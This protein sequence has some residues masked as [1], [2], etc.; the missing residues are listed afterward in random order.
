MATPWEFAQARCHQLPQGECIRDLGARVTLVH[1]YVLHLESDMSAWSNHCAAWLCC[2]NL[3]VAVFCNLQKLIDVHHS[4]AVL[5]PFY[6]KN[7][8][9][10]HGSCKKMIQCERCSKIQS[11]VISNWTNIP[12]LCVF[13]HIRHTSES[14]PSNL[15]I[16][17]LTNLETSNRWNTLAHVV[18]VSRERPGCGNA[19]SF[20]KIC[21]KAMQ[22]V[23]DHD[24]LSFYSSEKLLRV[25]VESNSR[26]ILHSMYQQ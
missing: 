5:F 16:D 24:L 11:D 10:G 20:S 22:H 2:Y 4:F 7:A 6:G 17:T 19:N 18:R 21:P 8:G 1:D 13:W 15:T 9:V 3:P 12:K 25:H 23:F 14:W 26:Y